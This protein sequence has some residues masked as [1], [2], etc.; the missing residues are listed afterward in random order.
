MCQRRQ[1]VWHMKVALSM[2]RVWP[3]V[4]RE[5]FSLS[6][7]TAAVGPGSNL[8]PSSLYVSP[9]PAADAGTGSSCYLNSGWEGTEY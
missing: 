3:S 7:Y 4:H 9:F 6:T 8:S 2:W 5:G 1:R